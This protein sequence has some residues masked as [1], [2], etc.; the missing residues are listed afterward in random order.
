MISVLNWVGFVYPW[1]CPRSFDWPQPGFFSK[2]NRFPCFT[3][4]LDPLFLSV[5]ATDLTMAGGH[6]YGSET[7]RLTD[8]ES[9]SIRRSSS[10]TRPARR[11]K[12]SLWGS[13]DSEKD[14][15]AL[16]VRGAWEI[17]WG[18]RRGSSWIRTWENFRVRFEACC[19]GSD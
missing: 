15:L 17:R 1:T 16:P 2:S 4:T 11:V 5:C 8:W 18:R 7:G 13:I 3:A 19:P 14:L 10:R 12:A 6:S 9:S